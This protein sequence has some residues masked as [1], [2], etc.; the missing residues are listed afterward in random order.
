MTL[1][2]DGSKKFI[3]DKD[4][5]ETREESQSHY[6]SFKHPNE[7]KSDDDDLEGCLRFLNNYDELYIKPMLIYKYSKIKKRIE[8]DPE[9][10]FQE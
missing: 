8:I 4:F 2:G 1:K 10:F 6:G 3:P 5:N 7:E 9:Q